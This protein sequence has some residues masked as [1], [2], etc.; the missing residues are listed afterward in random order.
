M[1]NRR[2]VGFNFSSSLQYKIYS[3]L[4]KFATEHA[5]KDYNPARASERDGWKHCECEIDEKWVSTSHLPFNI[6][7]IHL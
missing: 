6:K 3:S 5:R 2:K 7:Y 1:R 4:T